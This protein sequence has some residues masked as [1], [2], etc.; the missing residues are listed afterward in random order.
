MRIVRSTC[1]AASAVAVGLAAAALVP[2]ASA[3]PA[4]PARTAASVSVKDEGH[5][6]LVRSSGSVLY[7]E[8][9]ARGTLPGSVK[10]SFLYNGDP[11]VSAQI[12]I[13]GHYGTIQAHGSGRLSNPSSTSPSFKG[14][15]TITGSSGRYAHAHGSG[16]FYGVFYRRSY[17]IVV[18]TEG[19][20]HY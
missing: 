15:I 7:D 11:E 14:T 6:H 9:T 10:V 8:G 17:A 1:R 16:T 3:S 12:T 5:L 13:T 19:T 20:L 4:P 18:Q 2:G